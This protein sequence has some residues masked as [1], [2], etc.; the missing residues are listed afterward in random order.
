M[1]CCII[2][3]S[4]LFFGHL[5]KEANIFLAIYQTLG[6]T[7]TNGQKNFAFHNFLDFSSRLYSIQCHYGEN[8]NRNK[9]AD[10]ASNF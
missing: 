9:A 3:L 2:Y 1:F 4:L 7:S 8:C 10:F 5:I 6:Q